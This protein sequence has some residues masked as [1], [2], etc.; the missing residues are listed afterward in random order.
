MEY[1][2]I[3][4]QAREGLRGRWAQAIG[5]AVVAYIL[6]GILVGS[7]FLPQLTYSTRDEITSLEDAIN[8]LTTI[9]SQYGNSTVSFN[10]LGIVQLVIGGVIQLGYAEML[11][12]QHEKKDSA[13]DQLF[14]QFHRFGQGFAQKFL[15]GLYCFLWGLLFVIPGIVKAYSYAMTPYIMAENPHMTATEVLRES[16]RMMKG[17][18]WR[19]FCLQL[20]FFGYR[21]LS[22][23][24]FGLAELWVAPY[25][26]QAKAHFYHHISGRSAV[27]DMVEE[28]SKISE[29]L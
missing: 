6:G 1:S 11:L 18:K 12:K 20:S 25:V 5:V 24:T 21:L 3:R 16:A 2:A 28:L 26:G 15:R 14:S 17:N 13:F 29:G 7:S 27:R 19:L 10:L 22:L 9:T 23:V 4:A 8:A